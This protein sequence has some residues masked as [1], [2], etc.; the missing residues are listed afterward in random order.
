MVRRPRIG[1]TM[2]DPAGIGPEVI[3]KAL[4]SLRSDRLPYTPIVIGDAAVMQTYAKKLV[5]PNPLRSIRSTDEIPLSSRS[6]CWLLNVPSIA[7]DARRIGAISA[8]CGQ[9]AYQYITAAIQLALDG[10]LDAVVTAPIHKEALQQAGVPYPGH[11]EIFADMTKTQNYC[12]MLSSELISCSLVTAHVGF[13]DVADLLSTR[14]ILDVI[15]LSGAAMRRMR[16][17]EPKLLVC[18]LNPH[19][20]EHG[21][22]G[23]QEEERIIRPAVELAREEGWNITGPVPPDTAFVPKQIQTTDCHICMYHDQGLIP[24]KALAFDQAMNITLGLPIIRTS[25]DHGTAFDIAGQNLADSSSMEYA[26]R[27]ACKLCE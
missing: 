12:M 22:F 2:G 8:D 17:R 5:C 24:L 1:I 16:Q 20:G 18:G 27:M 23:Q 10:Q 3:F 15:R 19:A 6:F 7:F 4:R 11:T 25:V 13:T 14:A 21:L 26:I 9:A